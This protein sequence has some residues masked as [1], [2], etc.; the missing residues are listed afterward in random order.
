MMKSS[1]IFLVFSTF[2]VC[3]SGPANA[4]FE[5]QDQRDIDL[6][7]APVD[8]SISQDGRWTFILTA[9]GSVQVLSFQGELVQTLEGGTGFN[10]IEFSQLGNRLILSSTRNKAVRVLSLDLV[11]EFDL[12]GSPVRGPDIAPV[13]I[14]VFNDFQ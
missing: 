8:I 9:E 3:I 6:R 1:L 5:L 11:H 14:A 12:T 13:V 7:T 10:R 2:L 4:A